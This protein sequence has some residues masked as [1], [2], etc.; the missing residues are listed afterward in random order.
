MNHMWGGEPSELLVTKGYWIAVGAKPLYVVDET[1]CSIPTNGTNCRYLDRL[2]FGALVTR[3][4]PAKQGGIDSGVPA[5]SPKIKLAK[6]V[7]KRKNRV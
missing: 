7:E 6:R 5:A 2:T 3:C 1:F 4:K